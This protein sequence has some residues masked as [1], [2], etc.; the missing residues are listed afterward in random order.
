MSG[1][2]RQRMDPLMK[3]RRPGKGKSAGKANRQ[4]HPGEAIEG[5]AISKRAFDAHL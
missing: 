2:V 3:L 1:M 5:A 4:S